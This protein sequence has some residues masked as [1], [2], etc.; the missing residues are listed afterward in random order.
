MILLKTQAL[1]SR[2][3]QSLAGCESSRDG[4]IFA[5]STFNSRLSQK[6]E[7]CK[8][9]P[10]GPEKKTPLFFNFE[11]KLKNTPFFRFP[12]TS[13]WKQ[14]FFFKIANMLKKKKKTL[15]YAKFG[16][17]M[18]TRSQYRVT[19]PGTPAVRASRSSCA[20]RIIFCSPPPPPTPFEDPGSASA[21]GC[22]ILYHWKWSKC[23]KCTIAQTM[24][25]RIILLT[26]DHKWNVSPWLVVYLLIWKKMVLVKSHFHWYCIITNKLVSAIV[27]T[28]SKTKILRKVIANAIIL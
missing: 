7:N 2:R 24:R 10:Q 16:T 26:D 23:A 18:R 3:H 5:W 17:I 27:L 4:S 19:T 21:Y 8:Q 25:Q 12:S 11:Y 6:T 28:Y 1:A 13:S 14:P 15:F 22:H 20:L 9:G